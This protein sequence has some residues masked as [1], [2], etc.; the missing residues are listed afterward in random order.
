MAADAPSVCW[1][2]VSGFADPVPS[3]WFSKV[4]LK[5]AMQCLNGVIGES[6]SFE[7]ACV[8]TEQ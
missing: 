7:V 4:A 2:V 1:P 6:G 5:H 3:K 8:H